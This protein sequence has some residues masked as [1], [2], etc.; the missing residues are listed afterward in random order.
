MVSGHTAV[1]DRSDVL[2]QRLGFPRSMFILA[3][4]SQ[5]RRFRQAGR[6]E[7]GWHGWFW[8]G[9]RHRGDTRHRRLAKGILARSRRASR[10]RS[11]ITRPLWR[12]SM[13]G[14]SMTFRYQAGFF[15]APPRDATSRTPSRYGTYITGL[16]RVRPVTAPVIVTKHTSRPCL[17]F[18]RRPP[19]NRFTRSCAAARNLSARGGSTSAP[20]VWFDPSLT[21]TVSH[22]GLFGSTGSL[23]M[24]SGR[25]TGPSA[26]GRAR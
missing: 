19:L 26:G 21:G 13:S 16:V 18:P 1:S 3:A 24:D 14:C 8:T 12:T 20:S 22:L 4:W 17:L 2:G 5:C 10:A 25:R 11:R 15:G 9:S 6:P 23:D 7:V